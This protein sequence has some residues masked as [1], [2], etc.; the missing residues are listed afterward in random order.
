MDVIRFLQE[1]VSPGMIFFMRSVTFLGDEGFY[2]LILPVL[3]WCWRKEDAI[4]VII[5][6]YGTLL[7]NTGLKEG[8]A[9]S[10]P[11]ES[12][13]LISVVKGYSFPSGHAQLAMVLWGYYAW[14]LKTYVI[15]FLLIF[16]TGFSRV[17]LGVH[18]LQDV[19]GGWIIGFGFLFLA[20]KLIERVEMR[21]LKFPP[22]PA[23]LFFPFVTGLV[24]I[25]YPLETVIK[26]GGAVGGMGA[27]IILEYTYVDLKT[28]SK[29]SRQALKILLGIGSVALLRWGLKTVLPESEIIN[30][31]RY[32]MVGMWIGLGIPWV[33]L[34]MKL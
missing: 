31:L 33:F 13:R 3:F 26:I 27:G 16:L 2:F 9:I 11:P 29:V 4:P 6:L 23:A 5:L 15:P 1:F 12:L 21:E 34:R 32:T 18:Y 24:S 19:I 30:W 17:F 8:F 22:I 20:V 28:R 14:R 25:L 10:R 7:F